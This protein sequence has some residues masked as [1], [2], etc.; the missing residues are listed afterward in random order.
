MHEPVILSTMII[1][2]NLQGDGRGTNFIH[3]SKTCNDTVWGNP[4]SIGNGYKN[5][6][7]TKIEEVSKTCFEYKIMSSD[8]E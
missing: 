3:R 8:E 6:P 5:Q 2:S 4:K 7:T 1:T